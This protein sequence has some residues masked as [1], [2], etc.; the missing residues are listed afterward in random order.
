MILFRKHHY[1]VDSVPVTADGFVR[2]VSS[3]PDG[4][5]LMLAAD[6]LI[7]DY[8]SMMVDFANTGRPMLFYTYDLDA[9]AEE[10]RG[11]YLDF[12][13][14]VPGPLLRTTDEVAEAL[15]DLDG[16]RSAHDARYAAF[17]ETFCELDDGHAAS[18]VVDCLLSAERNSTNCEHVGKRMTRIL[19]GLLLLLLLLV[20]AA[21]AAA[22][23]EVG[24]ADDGVMLQRRR[25][26][27]R[28]GRRVEEA[29]HR[30]RAHPRVLAHDHPQQPRRA[31]RPPASTQ[32]TRT[33]LST[34]GTGSTRRSIASAPR[35]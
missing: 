15:R 21:P 34:R 5:E 30:R 17:R 8:S 13:G 31:R 7:T 9:Y 24:I 25:D 11:F 3:Y 29:R 2:D 28:G 14:T 23:P 4:T 18:R 10:I 20:P 22:A 19:P 35:A 16:V 1:V 32:T 26:G 6:V 33:I 12:V 27:R